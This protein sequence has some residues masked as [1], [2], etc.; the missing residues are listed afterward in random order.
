[1][2]CLFGL[3]ET[4]EHEGIVTCICLGIVLSQSKAHQN[5][6]PQPVRLVDRGFKRRVELGALRILHPIENVIA[7][8]LRHVIEQHDP[9]RLDHRKVSA[10]N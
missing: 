9:L 10:V 3:G 1:L 4:L 5:R 8:L 2:Q 7:L 6:E